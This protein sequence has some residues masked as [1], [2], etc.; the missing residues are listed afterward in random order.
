VTQRCGDASF[1]QE[2][3]ALLFVP[4]AAVQDLHRYPAAALGFFRLINLAHASLPDR[5]DDQVGTEALARGKQERKIETQAD[6]R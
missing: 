1:G 5:T 6:A 2:A 4:D 3:L